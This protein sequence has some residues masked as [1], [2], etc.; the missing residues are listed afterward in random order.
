MIGGTV[1]VVHKVDFRHH[2]QLVVQRQ[3]N[4]HAC[5]YES[6]LDLKMPGIARDQGICFIRTARVEFSREML[7][8]GIQLVILISTP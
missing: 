6:Y 4:D 5:S 3:R 1:V 2:P 7:V 8:G